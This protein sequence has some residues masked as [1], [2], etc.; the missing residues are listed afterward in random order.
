MC[1]WFARTRPTENRA[2]EQCC[3]GG[4][5]LFPVVF[6]LH[7]CIWFDYS[8]FTS[9]SNVLEPF[10]TQTSRLSMATNPTRI[11]QYGKDNPHTKSGVKPIV[12][13]GVQ[14]DERQPKQWKTH[15]CPNAY[16][17]HCII[18]LA[19]GFNW[20]CACLPQTVCSHACGLT[21]CHMV[22]GYVLFS[23]VK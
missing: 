18:F 14:C 8:V 23:S 19:R 1:G 10:N 2:A 17:M 15:P 21:W 6:F 22:W 20:H 11:T 12:S 13:F 16:N 4:Y 7:E 3:P 9:T 5:G